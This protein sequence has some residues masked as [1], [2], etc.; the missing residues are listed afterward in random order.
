M[1]RNILYLILSFAALLALSIACEDIL[2]GGRDDGTEFAVSVRDAE[3]PADAGSMFVKVAASGNWS[4]S[5]TTDDDS[6]PWGELSVASGSGN[7]S[8]VVLTY[9]KNTSEASR[10]MNIVLASADGRKQSACTVVQNPAQSG[11]NG[12]VTVPSGDP[13]PV[14]GW[15]ELPAMDENPVFFTHYQTIGSTE[16]RSWSFLWDDDALVSHWVAYPLNAWMIGNGSRTDAWGLD[17]KLPRD[18]QPVLYSGFKGGYDRGHQL[19]SADRLFPAA[20]RE[21]FY[22][23]NMT[24]QL[25]GLNQKSWANL[26][27]KVREWSKSFDTLYVVT[28]CVVEGSTKFAQDNDGKNVTVPVGYYKA[29]LGYKKNATFGITLQTSGYTSIAFWFDHEA[30]SG[31]YMNMAMTVDAL[32]EKT[33]EDFFVNLPAAIG[34]EKADKVES[35]RDNWWK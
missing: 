11:G 3:L 32:E 25:G 21:T 27:T 5:L 7:K 29:L 31:D 26:E 10:S 9:E 19:P 22:G 33:G 17:P 28:G 13:D 15:L 23:T 14:C 34:Q 20:N 18:R 1:N 30:Y 2:S 16:I 8:N 6:A 35:T 4:L 24:P 12:G